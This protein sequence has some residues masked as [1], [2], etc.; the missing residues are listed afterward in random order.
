MAKSLKLLHPGLSFSKKP[1]VPRLPHWEPPPMTMLDRLNK[2]QEKFQRMAN[3]N[4]RDLM[5]K[6]RHVGDGV[7][8]V[9]LKMHYE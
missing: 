1:L 4:P 5:W 9:L 6:T 2:V 8:A 7:E 3:G